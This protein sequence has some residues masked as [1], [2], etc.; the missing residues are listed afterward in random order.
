MFQ[1]FSV[2]LLEIVYFWLRENLLKDLSSFS[3]NTFASLSE[4]PYLAFNDDLT[5]VFKK[6]ENVVILSIESIISMFKKDK[7]DQKQGMWLMTR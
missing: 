6:E 2:Q 5:P 4:I 3:G 7:T 1:L